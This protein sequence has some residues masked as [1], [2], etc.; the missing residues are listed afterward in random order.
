MVFE[1]E[2]SREDSEATAGAILKAQFP[3]C[4][5]WSEQLA[6]LV[7][8]KGVGYAVAI[9]AIAADFVEHSRLAPDKALSQSATLCGVKLS[10][11]PA[12]M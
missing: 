6:G 8:S 12:L 9:A 10:Q 4:P 3:Q 5:A 11:V 2:F 7:H 1:P